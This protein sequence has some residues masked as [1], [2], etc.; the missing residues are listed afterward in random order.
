M[1]TDDTSELMLRRKTNISDLAKE[2]GVSTATVD[3]VINRRGGVRQPTVHRV[4]NAAERLGYH[5]PPDILATTRPEPMRLAFVL[6]MGANRYLQML[7]E[8][9]GRSAEEMKPF[10]VECQVDLV[11]SFNP[12]ALADRLNSLAGDFDG[13]AFMALEHPLVREAVAALHA[14]DMFVL[15]L[16]S[17]LSNSAR[18]AFVGMDN[19]AAGRTAGLLLGR[20]IGAPDEEHNK[21]AMFAGSLSYRGHEEREMGFR[22]ILA[23]SFPWLEVI[24][25]REG[26]DD[27]ASNFLQAQTLLQQHPDLVGIYNVGGASEGIAR[28]LAQAKRE[29]R[30]AFIGHGLTRE[31]RTLLVDGHIDAIINVAPEMLMRSAVRIFC[32]LRDGRPAASGVDPIPIGIFLSENLP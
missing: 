9:I 11:T 19:R 21:V 23:E 32:N 18:T 7:A 15:T 26:R 29:R 31:T 1:T 27:P 16:I 8:T 20:F 5:L 14:E 30:V 24:G 10:N 25:L 4:L 13:V 22:H 17:D 6:P 28:A 3:R 12:K 2:A